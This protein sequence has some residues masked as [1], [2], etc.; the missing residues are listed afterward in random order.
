LAFEVAAS[1]LR[2]L[3]LAHYCTCTVVLERREDKQANSEQR[4]VE[5][6]H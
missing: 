5:Q 4:T 1:A 6:E 2:Y 3:L